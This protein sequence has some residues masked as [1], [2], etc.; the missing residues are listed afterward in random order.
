MPTDS[1]CAAPVTDEMREAFTWAVDTKTP[2]GREL[3]A[4]M[5]RPDRRLS[6]AL[7][8]GALRSMVAGRWCRSMVAPPARI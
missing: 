5:R 3:L 1:S 4:M 8:V 2:C 7:V 6:K